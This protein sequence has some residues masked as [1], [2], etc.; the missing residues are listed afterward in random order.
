MINDNNENTNDNLEQE[1]E[2]D[3]DN[4]TTDVSAD[5]S[6]KDEVV[7]S[8]TEETEAVVEEKIDNSRSNKKNG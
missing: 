3:L 8:D 6:V 4:K 1:L 5:D 7:A 2:Q